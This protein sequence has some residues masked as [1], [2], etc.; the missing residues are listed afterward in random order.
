M[1]RCTVHGGKVNICDYGSINSNRIP[2]KRMKKKK[3]KLNTDA[4][5]ASVNP[6]GHLI[7]FGK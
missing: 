7:P 2:P 1:H 5:V 6:N 4:D 3:K